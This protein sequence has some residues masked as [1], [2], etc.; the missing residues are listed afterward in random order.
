MNKTGYP[1]VTAA[2]KAF[3]VFQIC[4]KNHKNYLSEELFELN[5]FR[6]GLY[7]RSSTYIV[8]YF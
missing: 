6:R 1:G 7:I 4:L 3:I 2:V 8:E 5:I